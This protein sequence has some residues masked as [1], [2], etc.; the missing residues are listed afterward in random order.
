MLLKIYSSTIISLFFCSVTAFGQSSQAI[1]AEELFLDAKYSEAVKTCKELPEDE[2]DESCKHIIAKCEAKQ[3]EI[4][5]RDAIQAQKTNAIEK[6]KKDKENSLACQKAKNEQNYC[7]RLETIKQLDQAL[8]R[9]RKIT[10]ESGVT[11]LKYMHSTTNAKLVYAEENEK[12]KKILKE[13]GSD[14]AHLNCENAIDAK[15]IDKN[16]Y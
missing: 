7:S 16:C 10:A 14:V 15:N 9:E 2:V 5:N 6:M 13:Q 3:K 4:K 12:M 11:D 1:I 8:N